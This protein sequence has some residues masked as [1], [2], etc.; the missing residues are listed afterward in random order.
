MHTF[1]RK[2][3]T[4]SQTTSVQSTI[5]SRARSRQTHEAHSILHLQPAIGHQAGQRRLEGDKGDVQGDAS[6]PDAL[7]FGHDFSRVPIYANTPPERTAANDKQE[8]VAKREVEVQGVR[9]FSFNLG[10]LRSAPRVSESAAVTEKSV[11]GGEQHF[12]ADLLVERAP[13][14]QGPGCVVPVS[15]LPPMRVP[16]K[17]AG[18]DSFEVKWSKHAGAG[19]AD[20]KLRL[21]YNA[22]FKN[23]ADH[24]PAL[25][26][27]RQSAMSTWDITAGPNKARKG[28]S[29][30]IHDD[31]Y[32][33]AD[34]KAGN[35]ITDVN[36]YS[37]DNPGYADL[38]KNDDLDYSFTAEQTI[39]DTSQA[40]KVI[41]TRGPHTATVKGTHP[42][43]YG[44]IPKTLS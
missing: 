29:A 16:A 25:A 18:V 8:T 30:P 26:E 11:E 32:S 42:R 22:K 23:D 43:T 5:L 35:K 40:N 3:R 14:K 34:D 2:P 10:D 24:D 13:E 41:A 12:I 15:P 36:F 7:R 33:R 44:A 31:H 21:D 27:F 39:V 6:A 38:N 28:T 17:T 19:A 20:A 4:A 9:T 1:T 37:N